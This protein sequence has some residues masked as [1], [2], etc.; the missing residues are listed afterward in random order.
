MSLFDKFFTLNAN[1]IIGAFY[2]FEIEKIKMIYTA[3][4][5]FPAHDRDRTVSI[6]NL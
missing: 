3:N 4:L 1:A 2:I 6:T 5:S